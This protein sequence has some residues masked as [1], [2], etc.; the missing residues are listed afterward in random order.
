MPD[1]NNVL[2]DINFNMDDHPDYK[3]KECGNTYFQVKMKIKDV[4]GLLLGSSR[5]TV[6]IPYKVITCS[7]CGTEIDLDE[8]T[9]KSSIT[10]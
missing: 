6:H 1:N 8:E 10:L 2:G 4:P 7:N 3:C 9:S 5:K